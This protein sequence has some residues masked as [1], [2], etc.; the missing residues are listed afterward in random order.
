M[1]LRHL[2]FLK[3]IFII[4]LTA[5]GGPQAHMA[6]VLK[7]LVHE[8]KYIREEDLIELMALCQILP[9]PTSTQTITAIGLKKGGQLL[10]LSTLIVWM[11]P[12]VIVMTFIVIFFSMIQEAGWSLDFLR[13]LKPMAVG[14]IF[15][16]AL[17]ISRAVIKSRAQLLITIGS[18]VATLAIRSPF[19]YP[20]VLL[21]GGIITNF[22]IKGQAALS[23]K[24]LVIK[25]KFLL[26]FIGILVGAAI[27]G[28][29]TKSR[30]VLLFE[31]TYR[32]GSIIFGGG[33][34]LIPMMYEQFVNYK[35][36]LT[37][38]EFLAGYGIVQAIPGPVFSFSTYI[39]GMS[40]KE[41]GISGQIMGSLIATVGIF[42]PGTLLIFFVAPIWES[43]KQYTVIKKSL[44]GINAAASGMV[45]AAG[46]ILFD[47][48]GYDFLHFAIAIGT[49]L[50]L[51]L[52][53]IPSPVI[54]LIFLF[55][56]IILDFSDQI[57]VFL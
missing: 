6:M 9:G 13:F 35:D 21:I 55:L 7:I 25:W 46:F 26:L 44:Q 22:T 30:P 5:F 34:V 40:L 51:L 32:Y 39:G 48:I 31:N 16:A 33:Q 12:A 10:A 49:F 14:F 19:I 11:L 56:G 24:K 41:Y 2:A 37:A 1:F 53:R 17:K 29:L 50:L 57:L 18:T 20:L 36:Y 52:T 4:A 27:L 28:A 54:V 3:D 42:L 43:L 8:K 23:K 45:A 47:S 38:Q 15:Y